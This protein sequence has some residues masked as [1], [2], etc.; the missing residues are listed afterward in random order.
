MPYSRAMVFSHLAGE[1][2]L[3][4]PPILAVRWARRLTV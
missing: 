4:P 3:A 1:Y 2:M